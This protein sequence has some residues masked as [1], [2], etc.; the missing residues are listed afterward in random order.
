LKRVTAKI[1]VALSKALLAA[2][3]EQFLL[4]EIKN[5]GKAMKCKFFHALDVFFLWSTSSNYLLC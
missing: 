3:A 2:D 1:D 4:G 5:L